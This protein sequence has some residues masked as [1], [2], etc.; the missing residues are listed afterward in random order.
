MRLLLPVALIASLAAC[1]RAVDPG[2]P[3]HGPD[4]P[5]PQQPRGGDDARDERAEAQG[6]HR[7]SLGKDSAGEERVAYYTLPKSYDPKGTKKYPA[8]W[9]FHGGKDTTMRGIYPNFQ[10]H[11]DKDIVFIFPNGQRSNPEE[12]AWYVE[13][14]DDHR[15]I[16]VLREAH[17]QIAKEVRLDD[18]RQF[19]T[20][21]SAGA[22]MTWQLACE[23]NDLWDGYA[24]VSHSLRATYQADCEPPKAQPILV[25][26]GTSDTKAPMEGNLTPDGKPNTLGASA[27]AKYFAEAS[28]CG[29]APAA[30]PLPKLVKVDAVDFPGCKGKVELLTH[31]GG[32]EWPG[33]PKLRGQGTLDLSTYIFDYFD[34]D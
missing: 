20:G 24:G 2:P 12:G 17:R 33:G 10:D 19:A 26:A 34:I 28:G 18:D 22:H 6:M 3:G 27:T 16:D 14:G 31:P 25:V 4:R 11:V 29:A 7:V 30:K 9:V 32:H 8:L 13:A 23:A 15:H 5:R 21:F 1:G